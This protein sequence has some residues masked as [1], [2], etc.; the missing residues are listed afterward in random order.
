MDQPGESRL[1]HAGLSDKEDRRILW[2]DPSNLGHQVVDPILDHR[3]D[4]TRLRLDRTAE[5]RA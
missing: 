4:R 1:A 2:C 5:R 3:I